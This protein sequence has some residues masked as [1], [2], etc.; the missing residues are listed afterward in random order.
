MSP[1]LQ[2]PLLASGSHE[3]E[4]PS[5]EI[6]WQPLFGTEGALAITRP[7]IL[8][9]ISVVIVVGLLLAG[10][11]R[12]SVVPG[13][14][15]M[16]VEGVY[17]LVRN[18]VARDIIGEH[19]FRRYIP[20][21]FAL[22]AFI[23][24]NNL[25]GALPPFQYPTMGRIAFPIV[26]ALLVYVVYHAVGISRKGVGG[27]LKGLVPSGLPAWI[28]PVVFLLE[29]VTYF[30]TRP[31]T[32]ALRLFGN[33]FAGHIIL[34]LF[35]SGAEYMLI[36]GG[37]LLKVVSIPTFLMAFLMT[38]FELLVQFLQ[39]YVFVLLSATYIADAYAEEH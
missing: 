15:Q 4:A 28:V 33:M 31:V 27:Y 29:V 14:G 11:R 34:V 2:A 8:A 37:L 35:I 19:H 38:L 16:A 10:T 21:L 12:L 30:V 20:L 9:L 24:V 6:F 26:L 39:A 23:Y 5:T 25:F 7:S 22:F 36:D 18:T 13:K 32:L 3:F 17:N 1:E